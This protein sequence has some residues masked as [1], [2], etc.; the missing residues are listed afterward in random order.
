MEERLG[1]LTRRQ[2]LQRLGSAGLGIAAAGGTVSELLTQAVAAVPKR[3]KL[4]DIEHVVF[5]MQENRSFDHYFGTLAGVRG[6][7]DKHA[8]RVFFQK[9]GA[10]NTIHPFR[11]GQH[12][13]FPDLT[14]DWGPQHQSWDGGKLDGF[15]RAHEASD[16]SGV[17][18]ETMG[19][20]QRSD[21][22][23]YYALADA[24]TICDAY[25]C[26]VIGP[27]D[28]NRLYAMSAT[29]DPDGAHGGPLVQTNVSQRGPGHGGGPTFT[30]TTM[31]EQLSAHRVSWKVYTDSSSGILDN[32]LTY[33]QRYSAG[34][35]LA[36]LGLEPTYPHDFMAD[37]A[38]GSLPQ[39]SWLMP[40]I[41][42]SEHPGF[43]SAVAGEGVVRQVVEALVSHPET[44]R[45][46]VLFVNW[47][48]NGGFFDHV[49]PPTAP[50]GTRGEY[51]T[52]GSLPDKAQ[53]IRGPIGLGFRVPMLVVSPFSR[54]GFVCSDTFDHT[55]TLRFLEARFGAEVPNL[56][57]WRRKTCGDLTAAFDFASPPSHGRPRL[58]K[59]HVDGLAKCSTTSEQAPLPKGR[60]PKQEKG[61]RPRPSGLR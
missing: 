18:P 17:G 56:S 52:V 20:Y 16:P 39:V 29:I 46:T 44:W 15:L 12:E 48:E 10:G 36:K 45:K 3:G 43:A 55:S 54:G 13:C 8:R 60:F 28:P 37:L 33:F 59:V 26:S 35:K 57:A 1:G 47:D 5:L 27:T 22:P 61:V 40:S 4:K 23:F 21:I 30:W 14:H 11:L 42:S 24:F 50:P 34:S 38:H 7:G 25:H 19:C 32:P 51:L 2:A 49:K 41:F 58:P 53:G 6:F 31:P 9:D